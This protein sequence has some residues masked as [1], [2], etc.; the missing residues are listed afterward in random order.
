[1]TEKT[2]KHTN[3][4]KAIWNKDE[5]INMIILEALMKTDGFDSGAGKFSVEDW[6]L[7]INDMYKKINI[8]PKDS[9]Y[10]IGCGSGAFIYP[11]FLKNH[12]VGGVDYSENLL[13][14]SMMMMPHMYFE[15]KEAIE[16]KTDETYDIV[17]SHSVFQYFNDLDYCK[18]VII[19][20]IKKAKRK[21]AILD[22]NDESKKDAY[23][24]I[25]KG[26]MNKKEYEKKYNGLSHI[27][28]SKSWF[29]KIAQEYNLKATI[30]DQSF[31]KYANSDLR[32]NV[33]FEK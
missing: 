4:W 27:F 1:M 14:L 19:K 12:K 26:Y 31:S 32:F 17:L 30:F 23:L 25:R 28:Y 20:M 10:E 2:N 3:N 18:K 24:K 8:L 22:I 33:V 5:R 9:I 13:H 29:E 7:Y 16:M 6:V 21:V 15:N 11:L